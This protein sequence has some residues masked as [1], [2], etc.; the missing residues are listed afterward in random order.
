ME[1]L[2]LEAVVWGVAAACV[3]RAAAAPSVPVRAFLG[4][5]GAAQ[6]CALYGLRTGRAEAISAGHV[7]FTASVWLGALLLPRGSFELGLVQALLVFTLVTRRALGH[8]MFAHARGSNATGDPRYDALYAAPLALSLLPL[9][10][11]K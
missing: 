7:G 8:C 6:A 9:H 2:L 10:A 5:C 3:A 1:R 4:A 11:R